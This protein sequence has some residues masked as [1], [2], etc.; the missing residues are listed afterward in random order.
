MK[1]KVPKYWS[2]KE[3]SQ[4]NCDVKLFF[5]DLKQTKLLTISLT[6]CNFY[7]DGVVSVVD[8]N[9]GYHNKASFKNTIDKIV[10]EITNYLKRN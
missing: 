5:E 8:F 1:I 4:S 10:D 2:H 9:T 7:Y 6:K 3:T